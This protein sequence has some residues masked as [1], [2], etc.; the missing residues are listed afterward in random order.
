MS[1]M[2]TPCKHQQRM[3]WT[4][5]KTAGTGV[6]SC[7]M[8]VLPSRS[9]IHRE[10]VV[11]EDV[12]PHLTESCHGRIVEEVATFSDSDWA[13]CPELKNTRKQKIIDGLG[14]SSCPCVRS[15]HKG[16]TVAHGTRLDGR[17]RNGRV[18]A[19][20]KEQLRHAEGQSVFCFFNSVFDV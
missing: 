3:T 12:K 7:K 11:S 6:A 14:R 1:T 9:N 15:A 10:R 16:V 17:E 20:F 8:I 18:A 13:G 2:A 5:F 19:L 4:K